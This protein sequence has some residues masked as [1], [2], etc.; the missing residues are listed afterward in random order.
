MQTLPRMRGGGQGGGITRRLFDPSGRLPLSRR[1]PGDLAGIGERVE[2]FDRAAQFAG[3]GG[4]EDR[5]GQ[6]VEFRGEPFALRRDVG[7]RNA[8]VVAGV[9]YPAIAERDLDLSAGSA[10]SPPGNRA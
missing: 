6:R 4:A 10:A 7:A 2:A 1:Q 5:H 8:G 9:Q 3:A